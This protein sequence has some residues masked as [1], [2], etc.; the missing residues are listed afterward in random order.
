MK[1]VLALAL[2]L[3]CLFFCAMALGIT[4]D[5]NRYPVQRGGWYSS[6]EEVAVYLAR[7]GILPGNYLTKREAQRLGWDSSRGNLWS[8]AQGR[9]IGGDRFGNYEGNVPDA[10][11]RKWTE[12]DIDYQGGYRGG[13]RIV[14]ST[15][16]LIYYTSDHYQSFDPVNVVFSKQTASPKPTSKRPGPTPTKSPLHARVSVERGMS[17]TAWDEVACYLTAFGELPPNYISI[18]DAKSLGFRSKKDNMGEVA[19]EFSI[20]GGVFQNRE[21]L[22]PSSPG[23]EWRECDVDIG[24]DGKR[25]K[26]RLLYSSDGLMFL[27]RDQ[28]KHFTEVNAQ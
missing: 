2:F 9:S 15:D 6:M 14:F 20:G 13:K 28:Y 10:R 19:P 22:L 27:T 11:G 25:G 5:A 17:Y 4:V 18:E 16:G 24:Q 7:Y 21:G 8:V 3:S 12:C 1:R 26:H 23:R